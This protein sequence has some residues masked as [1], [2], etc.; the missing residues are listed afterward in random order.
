M[1]KINTVQAHCDIPC[2]VYDP[3]VIQYSALSIV[4]FMDLINDEIK[5]SEYC[6]PKDSISVYFHSNYF[7]F[8]SRPSTAAPGVLLSSRINVNFVQVLLDVEIRVIPVAQMFDNL[9]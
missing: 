5:D 8:R 9:V 1:F 7:F 2:K 3:S 6:C 4:R